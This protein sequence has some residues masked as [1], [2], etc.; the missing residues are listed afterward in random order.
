MP[1]RAPSSLLSHAGARGADARREAAL[2]AAQAALQDAEARFRRLV[3]QVPTV[4]YICDYDEAVSIRYISPQIEALTGFPPERWTEDPQFWTSV[5]H[6]ADRDWVIDEMA[7]R[8]RE[9]IPVDFEYRIV[10][11]DGTVV[12]L[13]DQET[14]VR[15]A[16]GRPRYSQ[17]VLVDLTELRSAQARLRLSEAQMST[18]VESAP[19]PGCRRSPTRF[20]GRSPASTSRG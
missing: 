10:A 18:I 5:V 14:I 4:T 2:E 8:T 19:M 11:E 7:R 16:D 20:A 3:E 9:E 1:S 6:P 13:L 17:G 15:G 12:H